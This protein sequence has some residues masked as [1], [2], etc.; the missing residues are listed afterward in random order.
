MS[1][2]TCYKDSIKLLYKNPDYTLVHAYVFNKKLNVWMGH[3]WIEKDEIVI[4]S[5]GGEMPKVIYYKIARIEWDECPRIRFEYTLSEAIKK[6]ELL[7]LYG[8]WDHRF[9]PVAIVK[10]DSDK[11]VNKVCGRPMKVM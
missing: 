5:V 8:A 3:A 7:S 11:P 6:I 1:K 2:G 10:I 4:D 9:E